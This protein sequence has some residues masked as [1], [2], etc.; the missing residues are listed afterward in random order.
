MLWISLTPHAHV[1]VSLW[2]RHLFLRVSVIA[3]NLCIQL[4]CALLPMII[5]FVNGALI[6]PLFWSNYFFFTTFQYAS[7]TH[8]H[9]H[10][11][12]WK[13]RDILKLTCAILHR[14]SSFLLPE[15]NDRRRT[16]ADKII[17]DIFIC[18]LKPNLCWNLEEL[19]IISDIYIY[20]YFWEIFPVFAS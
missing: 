2:P 3:D 18:C 13:Q 17:P 8:I 1:H 15:L 9:T 6:K 7:F 10:I 14:G 11:H 5:E 12:S 4:V 20:I 16:E 19:S